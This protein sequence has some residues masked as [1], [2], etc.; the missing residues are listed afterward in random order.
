MACRD[1]ETTDKDCRVGGIGRLGFGSG[2]ETTFSWRLDSTVS[3][4]H[5]KSKTG[6]V[7]PLLDLKSRQIG[8]V[9]FC[10]PK[11]VIRKQ[12]LF[13]RRKRTLMRGLLSRYDALLSTDWRLSDVLV[14][15]RS[16]GKSDLDVGHCDRLYLV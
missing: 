11:S 15:V 4:F 12:M 13:P 8:R 2:L 14:A 10:S 16:D 5:G 9:G 1:I 3:E 7:F 6:E